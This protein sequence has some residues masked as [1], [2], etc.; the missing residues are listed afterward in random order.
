MRSLAEMELSDL[1][2][3]PSDEEHALRITELEASPDASSPEV[4]E[5]IR[6]TKELHAF[7]KS[8]EMFRFSDQLT[9]Q[10]RLRS[11]LKA[12]SAPENGKG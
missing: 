6:H 11:R 4:I 7:G 2:I 9:P 10:R 12:V 1:L 8:L 5:Q 3:A